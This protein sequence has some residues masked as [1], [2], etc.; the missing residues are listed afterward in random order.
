M[1]DT[2]KQ[3][4]TPSDCSIS[5]GCDKAMPSWRQKAACIRPW[6]LPNYVSYSAHVVA[7]LLKIDSRVLQNHNGINPKIVD[8]CRSPTGRLPRLGSTDPVRRGI[9]TRRTGVADGW[10]DRLVPVGDL[11]GTTHCSY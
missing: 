9:R 1:L 5:R 11:I 10:G 6:L 2:D 4:S 7:D 8:A 3:S